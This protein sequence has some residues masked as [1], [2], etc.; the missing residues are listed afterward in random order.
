MTASAKHLRGGR[1]RRGF[2]LMMVISVVALAAFLGYAMLAT[3][4]LQSRAS[5]NQIKLVSADYL[6]ESGLNVAMYY[7]QKPENAPSLNA[8]GYWAGTSQSYTLPNGLPSTLNVTVT[9]DASDPW[10]YEVV[11]TAEV[12][13]ASSSKVS[14]T[15]GARVYVRNEYILKQAA[16]FN[17][18]VAL[19]GPFTV[20]GDVYTTKQLSLKIGALG[21]PYVSGYGYCKTAQTGVGFTSPAGGWKTMTTPSQVAPS[22]SEL[23]LY[24]TYEV[25]QVTYNCTTLGT[26]SLT[27]TSGVVTKSPTVTN[28]AGIFY[29]NTSSG[30]AF[31]LGDNV[32]INGTLVIEGDCQIN[33]ANITITPESGYPALIVTGMLDIVNPSKVITA[34]GVCYVGQIKSTNNPASLVVA[35]QFNIQGGLIIGSSSATPVASSFTAKVNVTYDAT[36]AKASELSSVGRVSKGVSIVRWGLP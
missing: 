22:N 36:K 19:N 14:K 13:Q 34:K 11:S 5:S 28:P 2:A 29:R 35:S 17:N 33:G 12:G 26:S 10:T 30:G 1:P 16:A 15:T 6:A 7:L 8:S 9:R 31:V 23:N 32:T 3:S 24:K 25:D 18:N 21:T 20:A 4:T 27:G